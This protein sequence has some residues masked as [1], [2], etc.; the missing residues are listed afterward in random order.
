MRKFFLIFSIVLC[1]CTH[2]IYENTLYITRKYCG[3]LERVDI[4]KKYVRIQTSETY[5]YILRT[6]VEIPIGVKCYVKYIPENL[7]SNID[8]KVYILYFTWDGTEDLY[9]IRQNYITG[10]IIR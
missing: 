1:S 4:E 7:P 8:S 3:T 5:F 6:E 10:Q 9:M 2:Q